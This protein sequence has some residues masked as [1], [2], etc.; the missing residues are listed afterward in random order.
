VTALE[1]VI[2]TAGTTETEL[3]A[4]Q[5]H[6]ELEREAGRCLVRAAVLA[7]VRMI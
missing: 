7:R 5:D 2:R 4:V 1:T 3:A 6:E